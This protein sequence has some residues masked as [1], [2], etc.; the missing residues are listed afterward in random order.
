MKHSKKIFVFFLILGPD[1]PDFIALLQARGLTN[2]P[3][4]MTSMK[5]PPM[6]PP[7][8]GMPPLPALPKAGINVEDLERNLVQASESSM[9]KSNPPML[10]SQPPPG[11][12]NDLFPPHHLL[13]QQSGQ[14]WPGF[15]PIGGLPPPMPMNR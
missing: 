6:P 2:I 10:P 15:P 11:F 7:T 14:P 12:S 3:P 4:P 9:P 13:R 5:M 1:N 8:M